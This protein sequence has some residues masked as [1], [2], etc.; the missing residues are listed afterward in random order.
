MRNLGAFVLREDEPVAHPSRRGLSA[1]PQR[2]SWKSSVLPWAIVSQDR[3]EDGEK[4]SGDGDE[5]DH[6]G[7]AEVKEILVKILE[8]R[9]V[10]GR[11]EGGQE[12][13]GANAGASTSY[14][15]SAAP[16]AGLTGVWC[17]TSQTGD[18]S[19]TEC[20]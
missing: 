5:G 8:R 9:V 2:L 20:P 15:A 10:T 12:G 6:L 18:L 4:L 13:C 7:F 19:S 11:N 14:H 3:V 16:A 1:A 17:K